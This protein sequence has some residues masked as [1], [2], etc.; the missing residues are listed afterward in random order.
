ME[1]ILFIAAFI[2]FS[3]SVCFLSDFNMS[4]FLILISM[5]LFYIAWSLDDI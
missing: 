5:L 3:F 2:L 4:L 1:W